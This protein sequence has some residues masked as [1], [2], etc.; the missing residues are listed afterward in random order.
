MEKPETTKNKSAL[1]SIIPAIILLFLVLFYAINNYLWLKSGNGIA[2]NGEEI[3]RIKILLKEYLPLETIGEWVHAVR[4]GVVSPIYYMVAL[5]PKK[6]IGVSYDTIYMINIFWY[7]LII[8]SVYRLGQYLFDRQTGLL[9]AV[10][11]SLYP[12][13]YGFSRM[14]QESF[15]IVFIP[16]LVVLFL[17]KSDELRN[18]KYTI[19]LG[20]IFGTGMLLKKTSLVYCAAP[21]MYIVLRSLIVS[22]GNKKILKNFGLFIVTVLLVSGYRYSNIEYLSKLVVTPLEEPSGR[23]FEY[24]NLRIAILGIIDYQLTL[25]FLVLLLF[26]LVKFLKNENNLKRTIFMLWIIVPVAFWVFIPHRKMIRVFLPYLPA[27]ALISAYGIGRIRKKTAKVITVMLMVIIGVV[28]YYEF[29]FGIGL[30]L[31]WIDVK[32]LGREVAYF[33]DYYDEYDNNI[34]CFKP[35]KDYVYDELF[36]YINA[37]R[38]LKG[39]TVLLIPPSTAFFTDVWINY[40]IFNKPD[41]RVV[42]LKNDNNFTA[43]LLETMYRADYLLFADVD[44][45][46]GFI[47]YLDKQINAAKMCFEQHIQVLRQPLFELEFF[48]KHDYEAYKERILREA[49]K[50]KLERTFIGMQNK[51]YLLFK[52]SNSESIVNKSEE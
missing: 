20:L 8:I 10:I 11:L 29:S 13:I 16:V 28:Q 4:Y 5:L 19:I 6:L 12:A 17:F 42:I 43:E 25:P 14:F 39:P 26:G 27:L 9:G 44:I 1:L 15:A 50:Y 47:E 41:F 38:S 37:N 40:F 7:L 46:H 34:P 48:I 18:T 32:I 22:R 31:Y 33:H 49:K 30:D 35:H 2:I 36:S 45:E 51:K 24:E 3:Y 23:W 52:K 21:V